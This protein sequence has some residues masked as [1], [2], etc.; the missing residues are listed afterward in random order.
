MAIIAERLT[1]SHCVC[2]IFLSVT[3]WNAI[4]CGTF[5]TYGISGYTHDA[6]NGRVRGEPSRVRVSSALYRY[7]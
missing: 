3:V 2:N 7:V 4:Y 5:G 6:G 1:I